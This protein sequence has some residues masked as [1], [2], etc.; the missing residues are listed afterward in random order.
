MIEPS[1]ERVAQAEPVM[2]PKTAQ[3]IVPTMP[4]P[5]L[6]L[7]TKR[8]TRSISFSP[9]FPRSIIPPAMMKRAMEIRAMLF[10][11]LKP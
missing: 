10:M 6:T 7:P 8:S 4:R 11:E 9:I 2:D 3:E 5:P 1:K